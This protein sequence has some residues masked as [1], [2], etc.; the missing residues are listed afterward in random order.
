M[1]ETTLAQQAQSITFKIGNKDVTFETGKMA[2]SANGSVVL[3]VDDTVIL[4]TATGSE[5]PRP[6]I[7]FFPLLID[8]E[9]KMYSVGKFPGGYIKREGRPTEKATLTSR[10]IDRPIRPLWPDGYRNDV[11]VVAQPLSVDGINQPDVLSILGASMA[12]ELSGLPFLAP[13]GAVRVGRVE[14]EFVVNPTFQEAEVSDL[15]LVVAGTADSIMMVEA[16]ADFVSEDDLL[17]ALEFA[18]AHIKEQVKVQEQFRKQCGIE[19]QV[20]KPEFDLTNLNQFVAGQ[21]EADVHRAYH[22]FD[23]DKRKEI[24]SQAK[25]KLKEAI[26]ALPEDHEIS[27]LLK[28]QP[29]DFVGEAFKKVEKRVMRDMVVKEGVRADGRKPEEIRPIT[30][31][32]GLLPRAH[33]S[34]LFTRGSTQVLSVC[35]LGAPGDIQKLDGVDPTAEKRWM[36]HYSFPAYSVGEVRPLRGPGRREI[37]HGALAERA[38]APVL[39]PQDRFGYAI[40]VNSDVLESNGSTSMA[41]TCGTSL[42][43]MDAGVPVKEHISGIAMGLIKEGSDYV[44]LSD[45]QGIE[46]FLGDMDFKVTGTRDGVTALQMDIKIQG[47]SIEIMKVALEQARRGRLH[48]LEKML[49]AIQQPRPELSP[50]APRIMTMQIDKE[51][52]GTVIGPG[53]KMIRSITEETGVTIDIDESGLITIASMG[54]E[55]AERAR[56]IIRRLTAKIERG[57]LV[58]GKVVRIIPIGAFVELMPGK[59]GLLHIS[60]ISQRRIEKVE[61]EVSVGDELLVKVVDIDERGRINLTMKGIT[62]EEREQHGAAPAA[63]NN[64]K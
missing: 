5:N 26:A 49:A 46:D 39:P 29:L 55:G 3:K 45:I 24:I 50:W 28:D 61:D 15:D 51:Q 52:I 60:Q 17:R 56:E 20:F 16:G 57:M 13:V 14:G 30:C 32:V 47:I 34:A 10:L 59:D 37:G 1:A 21:V 12:L 40:R 48:I 31:E 25:D 62:D 19:K 9:E 42:A 64:G 54:G 41:S 11:Q 7:D 4:V 36:H 43:L 44:V 2:K 38:I 58:R 53:G 63:A 23:R 8:F 6:G 22:E 35:T 33:G 27:V 18:H